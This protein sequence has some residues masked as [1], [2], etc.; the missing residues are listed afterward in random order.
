M[1]NV[2]LVY[3]KDCPN[4]TLTRRNLRE[5]LVQAHLPDQWVEWEN[6]ASD[7]PR[8]VRGY[9]SPT[10]LVNGR[11]VAGVE[12][13]EGVACCRLYQWADS[14]QQG[15]PSVTVIAEALERAGRQVVA[16]R[17]RPLSLFRKWKSG[18]AAVPAVLIAFLPSVTCPACWP[19][20][21]AVLSALGLPFFAYDR[22]LLPLMAVALIGAVGSVGFQGWRRGAYGPT[23]LSVIA[24]AGIVVGRFVLQ[25]DELFYVG[26]GFLL[27][28][29]LWS[30]W[31][32]R[33]SATATCPSCVP[34]D[35]GVNNVN[36]KE[37]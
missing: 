8:Y 30:G 17:C 25:S 13:V 27:A 29:S 33:R 1:L 9:G 4:V 22:Y 24:S 35:S 20:Y 5:A 19:V 26:V 10:V 15:A 28:A 36:V 16:G 11:D 21:A 6:S 2:E 7:A 14:A 32:R 3:D 31:S 23:A 34:I 12:P 18:I 37:T